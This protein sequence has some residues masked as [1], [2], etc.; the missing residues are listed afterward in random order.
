MLPV[1]RELALVD[2]QIAADLLRDNPTL[3]PAALQQQVAE[4]RAG[5]PLRGL[6]N[7]LMLP[8]RQEGDDDALL[9]ITFITD[10]ED[11]SK[12]YSKAQYEA[13][14][15]AKKDP[16]AVVML[17]VVPQ[18]HQEGEPWAP[19]CTYTD[20]AINF[21]ALLAKFP[22]TVFGDICAPSYAPFFDEAADK[23][24]EA[25]GAFIPQ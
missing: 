1:D 19:G 20:G 16:S 7:L 24:G 22:Y 21:S 3:P 15:A 11:K 9:V 2:G 13:I 17:A 25:C 4:R 18:D 12:T 23:S 8:W 14:L 5:R 10:T 6:G